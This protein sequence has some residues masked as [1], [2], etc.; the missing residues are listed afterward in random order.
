MTTIRECT[1]NNLCVDCAEV[2]CIFQGQLIAD[3][4]KYHCDRG[5]LGFEHCESCTFLREY[6][7]SQREYNSIRKKVNE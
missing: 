7:K 3:C 5:E 1:K 2:N 4:P 6:A